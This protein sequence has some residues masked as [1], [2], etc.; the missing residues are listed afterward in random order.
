MAEPVSVLDVVADQW[1]VEGR[2]TLCEL[3]RNMVLVA[4]GDDRAY[5]CD[6]CVRARP[7]RAAAEL[8]RTGLAVPRLW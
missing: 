8:A 2:L 5:W 3:C 1:A 7:G 6:S 4:P